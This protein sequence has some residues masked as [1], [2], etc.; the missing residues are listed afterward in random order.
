M[1]FD[2][3]QLPYYLQMARAAM[4]GGVAFL[5]ARQLAHH[6]VTGLHR[7][8]LAQAGEALTVFDAAFAIVAFGAVG[9]SAGSNPVIPRTDVLITIRLFFTA[10]ALCGIV[11]QALLFSSMARVEGNNGKEAN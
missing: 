10:S 4:V 11:A 5:V 9:V 2:W 6:R 7:R 1:T 3:V 8:R